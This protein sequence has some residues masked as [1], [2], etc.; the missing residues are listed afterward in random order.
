[1]FEIFNTQ[2]FVGLI[3]LNFLDSKIFG[4]K[5][6]LYKNFHHLLIS[7]AKCIELNSKS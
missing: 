2:K 5:F 7:I 1:M 6:V 3:F 4:Y